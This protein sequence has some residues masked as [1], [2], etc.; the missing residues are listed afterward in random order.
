MNFDKIFP[1]Q[2]KI[3]GGCQATHAFLLS[4]ERTTRML[5]SLLIMLMIIVQRLLLCCQNLAS[6]E[7]KSY[8]SKTC[9]A[10]FY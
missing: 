8:S 5:Y 4:N 1:R 10:V 7:L 2:K 6:C 9:F 3:K